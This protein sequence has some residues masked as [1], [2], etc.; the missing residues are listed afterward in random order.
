MNNFSALTFFIFS[1]SLCYLY[2]LGR[3]VKL[4]EQELPSSNMNRVLVDKEVTAKNTFS[5]ANL[6][7]HINKIKS[8]YKLLTQLINE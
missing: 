5:K 7:K 4:R 6:K 2:H 1:V 8:K 3:F